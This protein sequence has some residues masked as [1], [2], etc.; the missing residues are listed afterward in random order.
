MLTKSIT[1]TDY[2]GNERTENFMF[3]LTKA[4]LAEL[5]LTTEGGLQVAIQRI[6][7]SKDIPEITKW[8]KK[9]IMMAYGEKS[10]DGRRFVKSKELSEEF[11]QTEA[12]SELFMELIS[13]E[14]AAANFISGVVPQVPSAEKANV[15]APVLEKK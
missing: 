11:L 4:E 14:N 9:I 10:L 7:D 3:N 2:D 5:N 12:Y 15:P 8:F 6:I 1:Y 13:D